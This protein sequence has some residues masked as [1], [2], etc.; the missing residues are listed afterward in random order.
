QTQ[1]SNPNQNPPQPASPSPLA[2]TLEADISKLRKTGHFYFAL[3][4]AKAG[5]VTPLR[6][7]PGTKSSAFAA[8]VA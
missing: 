3:T 6:S 1:T 5:P 4:R 2:Q 8:S 7:P